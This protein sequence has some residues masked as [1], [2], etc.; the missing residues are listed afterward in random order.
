MAAIPAARRTGGMS[1][2]RALVSDKYSAERADFVSCASFLAF[3][4]L[5]LV[6]S[7]LTVQ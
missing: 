5:P 7:A 2:M 4:F 1:P 3:I 6:V